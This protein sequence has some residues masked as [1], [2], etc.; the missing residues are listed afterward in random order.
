MSSY[1][2]DMYIDD[3]ALDVEWTEQAELATEWGEKW[4]E[5]QDV[6]LRA[7]EN[8]KIVRSELILKINK[9]PEKYLGEGIKPTDAKIEAAYRVHPKHKEAKEQWLNA[10]KELADLEVAKNEIA[11]TRKSALENLVTLHGQG[12]FAGPS[13]PRDLNKE[14]RNR[15]VSRKENNKKVRSTKRKRK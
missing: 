8:V 9:N 12:Y 15:K 4:V 13:M 7:D 14:R 11:F 3:T 1:V 10:K 6:F 2:K 5:A